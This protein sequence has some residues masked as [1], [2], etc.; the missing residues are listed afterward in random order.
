MAIRNSKAASFGVTLQPGTYL[1]M[2]NGVDKLVNAIRPTLGPFPRMVALASSSPGRAPE[3]LDDG[4]LIARRMIQLPDRDEDIGA[5]Y[6][7]HLLWRMREESGDGTATTAV[8]F[9]EILHQGVR[10]IINGGH[11]VPLRTYL[12][13]GARLVMGEI[14]KQARPVENRDQVMRIAE[15][16]C[17]DPPMARLLGEI[18]DTIGEFGHFELRSGHGRGLE[19][20]YTEGTYWE[21]P[22]HAKVMLNDPAENRAYLENAGVLVT[23]FMVEDLHHLVRVITEA[24]KAGKTSLLL[25]CNS[26]TEACVGFLRMDSTRNILPVIAVKT[27][28][29]RL[30]E[31]MAA[32]EDIAVLT[33]AEPMTLHAGETLESVA[34][35]HFG[36][37]R[38]V[39]AKDQFFGILGGQGDPQTIRRHFWRLKK[40]YANLEIGEARILV[41]K[42]IGRLMSGAAILWVGG[43]TEAEIN[44]RKDLAE[45]ASEAIRGA[46][47]SGCVPGG[48]MSFLGCK[49]VL[50]EALKCAWDPDEIAAYRI[51]LDAVEVPLRTIA[52]NAGLNPFEVM[53]ELKLAGPGCGFD[54]YKRQIVPIDRTDVLDSASVVRQAAYR[55]IFGA[56]LLLTVDVLIH[57]KKPETVVDT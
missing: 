49:Q 24:K 12:E 54:V 6:L 14:G 20:E 18:F 35:R 55:S 2:L 31:Q 23:D 43:T 3:L 36:Q 16:I 1:G 5:M 32:V 56:A 15:S 8:L 11:A 21:G 40:Y 29:S 19:C 7:R 45:R 46:M 4:G 53:A 50:I 9:G 42:R 44:V 57:H 26:I 48:G 47:M 28:Y 27:P 13:K 41:R 38:S 52:R 33:G 34:G 10:H 22:L 51:L 17:Y 30:D 37:V 39:W 25:I